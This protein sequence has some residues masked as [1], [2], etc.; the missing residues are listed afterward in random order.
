MDDWARCLAAISSA[1]IEYP[2]LKVVQVSQAILESGWGSSR[3]F[4]DHRNP[5]GM[6]FRRELSAIAKPITYTDHAGEE[7]QYCEFK[8]F[9]TTAKAYWLFIDRSVY[10][11]WR[12]HTTS[13]EAFLRFIAYA[14][15]IGG[16]FDGTEE[17]RRNKEKYIGKVL[18]VFGQARR[19]LDSF[20]ETAPEA[21][22]ASPTALAFMT[23]FS[24]GCAKRYA[25]KGVDGSAWIQK[26]AQ[27]LGRADDVELAT[28]A[29]QANALA[30]PWVDDA[31]LI[32][33]LI[34]AIETVR[35]GDGGY[36]D[37][38]ICGVLLGGLYGHALIDAEN[39]SDV[40]LMDDVHQ[41]AERAILL[42][43]AGRCLWD[44]QRIREEFGGISSRLEKHGLGKMKLLT[45]AID[46]LVRDLSAAFR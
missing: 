33:D 28:Y 1:T 24:L 39:A 4:Q 29:E 32:E 10:R 2:T 14:G 3:L 20:N 8:D 43:S 37:C 26:A 22:A 21:S 30:S 27:A 18:K 45:P 42:S 5:Y 44:E 9:E 31:E 25:M 6:K 34:R 19:L 16:P 17:D 12:E 13:P 40:S 46:V 38:A 23:C 36:S 7:D 35:S 41:A 11:G 15:Y